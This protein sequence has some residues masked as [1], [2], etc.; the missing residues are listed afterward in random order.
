[1]NSVKCQSSQPC[2]R[3][4]VGVF[5]LNAAAGQITHRESGLTISP[6][7]VD[8]GQGQWVLDSNTSEKAAKLR[9]TNLGSTFQVCHLFQ[10][11]GAHLPKREKILCFPPEEET[12]QPICPDAI[13]ISYV[14]IDRKRGWY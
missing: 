3:Q 1:M 6:T 12:A 10:R 11:A 2:C 7:G 4:Q 14:G 13:N 5:C 9:N 8:F